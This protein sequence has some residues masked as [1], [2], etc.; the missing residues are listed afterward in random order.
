VLTFYRVEKR[1][2]ILVIDQITLC[3]VEEPLELC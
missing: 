3:N 2:S 1:V